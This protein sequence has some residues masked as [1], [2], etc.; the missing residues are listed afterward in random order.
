MRKLTRKTYSEIAKGGMMVEIRAEP[1]KP[2]NGPIKLDQLDYDQIAM[3]MVHL[4]MAEVLKGTDWNCDE[5]GMLPDEGKI[6][7]EA[8][9]KQTYKAI[10]AGVPNFV[11]PVGA[12]YTYGVGGQKK[13]FRIMKFWLKDVF[14][15]PRAGL[16]L[17]IKN[18]NHDL[19]N[20]TVEMA[21]GVRRYPKCQIIGGG[22]NF[23]KEKVL[24]KEETGYNF[25]V[26]IEMEECL[27]DV[28]VH[29]RPFG[30]EGFINFG[31][32]LKIQLQGGGIENLI[33]NKRNKEA[34]AKGIVRKKRELTDK[35]KHDK[36]ARRKVSKMQDKIDRRAAERRTGGQVGGAKKKK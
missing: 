32:M 5:A 21:D 30:Q 12:E 3:G 25:I 34:K 17:I 19:K 26:T 4:M 15:A 22:E 24:N 11:V 9:N 23:E 27:M 35:E 13:E 1:K 20:Y 16:E 28:L 8:K 29:N 33:R 6:Y 18:S 2:E 7:V 36:K 10:V 31:A 14:W